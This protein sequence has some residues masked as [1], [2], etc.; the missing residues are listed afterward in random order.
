M[1]KD[2]LDANPTVIANQLNLN[3]DILRRLGEIAKFD[4]SNPDPDRG[5]A[6][7]GGR[8]PD[9]GTTFLQLVLECLYQW[10]K[11]KSSDGKPTG[12][13]QAYEDLLRHGVTFPR[14]EDMV[15]YR[16][17]PKKNKD[18]A[19]DHQPA[20]MK[21]PSHTPAGFGEIGDTEKA[22]AKKKSMNSLNFR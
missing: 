18:N 11:F 5:R 2:C 22:I 13:T 19:S 15:F 16:Q 8:D 17:K 9:I 14:P 10:K 12:F 3:N 1:L 20:N 21:G 4:H 6:I 7:F